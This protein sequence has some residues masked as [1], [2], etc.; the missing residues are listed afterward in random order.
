MARTAKQ[1]RL[2]A[3]LIRIADRQA[4]GTRLPAERELSDTLGVSRDTLR[5]VLKEAEKDGHV[6]IRQGAG[7]F[8]RP[9]P[10]SQKLRLMSFTEEMRQRGLTPSSEMLFNDMVQAAIK[11]ARKLNVQ[12]GAEL[13]LLRRLRLADNSP[14][15]IERVYLPRAIFPQLQ[16]KQLASGS[17]YELLY[18]QYETL[19]H[20]ARQSIEA[21]VVTEEEAELLQIPPFSPALLV[22][23]T[24]SDEQG[25]TIEYA[26]SIYR[27][28]KYRFDVAVERSGTQIATVYEQ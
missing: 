27:A 15:A 12:P 9:K 23:R 13:F 19:A 8:I 17:L 11:V 14:V 5:R 3:E 7:I 20:S 26:K 24:V 6:E 1:Q 2:L 21:T 4:P 18:E 28:D 16:T 10:L 22:E 25:R